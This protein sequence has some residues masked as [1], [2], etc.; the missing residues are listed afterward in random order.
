MKT[1]IINF[2]EFTLRVMVDMREES[3][4]NNTYLIEILDYIGDDGEG[5]LVHLYGSGEGNFNWEPVA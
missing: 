4:A 2:G 1:A 5:G 3:M